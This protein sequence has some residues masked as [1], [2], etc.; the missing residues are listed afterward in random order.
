MD[1]LVPAPMSA[2]A[3]NL[4]MEHFSF[5][6]AIG[7]QNAESKQDG[8]NVDIATCLC[9][10]LIV[11]VLVMIIWV[12]MKCLFGGHSTERQISGQDIRVPISN[13]PGSSNGRVERGVPSPN[14]AGRQHVERARSGKEHALYSAVG[15]AGI[16][17]DI[18]G[19][20]TMAVKEHQTQPTDSSDNPEDKFKSVDTDLSY[21]NMTYADYAKTIGLDP[22]VEIN[23]REFVE[24]AGPYA[25]NPS[26]WTVKEYIDVVPRQGLRLVDYNVPISSSARTVPDADLNNLQPYRR[27]CM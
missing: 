18:A 14:N 3:D 23:H 4:A 26:R 6:N 20:E 1:D 16:T 27:Y 7:G 21:D 17:K 24:E 13:V 19:A 12:L 25:T 22:S 9:W 5:E 10:V 8:K 2:Q 15:D 11:V